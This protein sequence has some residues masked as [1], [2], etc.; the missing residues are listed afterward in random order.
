MLDFGKAQ[1]PEREVH[2][3]DAKVHQAAAARLCRIEEPRLA[4]TVGI[5]EH[6][7][8]EVDLP[9]SAAFDRPPQC[10]HG[11]SV[12]VGEIDAEQPV[13]LARSV[14][15]GAHFSSIAA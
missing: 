15:H 11:G 2:Q 9:Q 4:R 8:G 10:L 1:Q 13:G 3:M 5:V 7:V 6:Q 14:D 12:P